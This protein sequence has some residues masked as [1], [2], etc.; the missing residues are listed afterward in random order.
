MRDLR[1]LLFFIAI[2]VLV[3]IVG[4]DS[5]EDTSDDK[6]ASK[7]QSKDEQLRVTDELDR[8][9]I[10]SNIVAAKVYADFPDTATFYAQVVRYRNGK[11]VPTTELTFVKTPIG[12][13]KEFQVIYYDSNEDTRFGIDGGSQRIDEIAG[14]DRFHGRAI[15]RPNSTPIKIGEYLPV[16]G[17]LKTDANSI[18]SG[19]P[20]SNMEELSKEYPFSDFI[21]IKAEIAN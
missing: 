1:D 17:I 15:W 2:L 18:R 6:T 13:Q 20:D 5:K 21:C 14:D 12:S 9:L 19:D 3:N 8:R 11:L 10:P 7:T 16:L 4:C